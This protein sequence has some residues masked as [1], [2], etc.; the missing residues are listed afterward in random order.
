MLG[1][2][3]LWALM[4]LCAGPALHSQ[5]ETCDVRL[6]RLLRNLPRR[7]PRQSLS[8]TVCRL[9]C[10]VSVEFVSLV[11]ALD[12]GLQCTLRR[13]HAQAERDVK[14]HSSETCH[15]NDLLCVTSTVTIGT[16]ASK[17]WMH[18]QKLPHRILLLAS[19]L[20]AHEH[21]IIPSSLTQLLVALGGNNTR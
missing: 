15:A 17:S 6:S 5:S 10:V 16:I 3:M 14:A 8:L 18:Q 12:D 20:N 13:R 1:H 19:Y 21:T 2:A 4:R 11:L 7:C 9:Q